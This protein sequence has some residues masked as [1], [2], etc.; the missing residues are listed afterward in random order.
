MKTVK[1]SGIVKSFAKLPADIRFL[2]ILIMPSSHL[3]KK[4]KGMCFFPI[5][6][7]SEDYN[8]LFFV[9]LR[10]LKNPSVAY[11]ELYEPV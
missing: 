2:I 11:Q 7:F 10:S 3:F 1:L 9:L 5:S 6:R 4:G 8:H